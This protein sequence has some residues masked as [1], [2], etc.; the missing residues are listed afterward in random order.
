MCILLVLSILVIGNNLCIN[1]CNILFNKKV[2]PRLEFST[3][4]SGATII[5]VFAILI[6]LSMGLMVFS[7]FL[8][9]SLLSFKNMTT[10]EYKSWRRISYLKDFPQALGSPF[11]K[12]W[13]ENLRLYCR[14]SVPKLTNWEYNT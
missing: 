13:K 9:H 14:F 3:Y 6:S 10:W 12:G 2:F 1:W 5:V 11:S 7:L 4:D 8:F